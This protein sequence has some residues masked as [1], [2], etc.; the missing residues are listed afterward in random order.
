MRPRFVSD[1]VEEMAHRYL[2]EVELDLS[3]LR[4]ETEGTLRG[5][6]FLGE[7]K[8]GNGSLTSR[9]TISGDAFKPATPGFDSIRIGSRSR[10]RSR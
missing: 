4:A 9:S 1:L 6:T 7:V 5:R 10:C 2:D 3:A 8:A